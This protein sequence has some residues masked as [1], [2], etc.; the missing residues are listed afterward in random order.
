[1]SDC[2]AAL[3]RDWRVI[4]IRAIERPRS[5]QRL[6]QTRA[7]DT[8]PMPLGATRTRRFAER[9]QISVK[10]AEVHKANAMQKMC[11]NSRIDIVRYALL[12]GWL[13]DT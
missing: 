11:M 4:K 2:F 12:R 10:T 1:M 9:L 8:A 3:D 7:R 5:R 13:Q 6:E